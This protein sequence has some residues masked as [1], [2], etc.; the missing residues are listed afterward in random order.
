MNLKEAFEIAVRSLQDETVFP[1]QAEEAIVLLRSCIIQID[2]RVHKAESA[3][4]KLREILMSRGFRPVAIEDFKNLT[5]EVPLEVLA[6][7]AET[8]ERR[9]VAAGL[10]PDDLEKELTEAM[11]TGGFEKAKP[12][13]EIINETIKEAEQRDGTTSD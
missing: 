2:D 11:Q 3:N 13:I 12:I 6:K 9:M 1:K 10:N 7:S 5:R 8:F 4:Q